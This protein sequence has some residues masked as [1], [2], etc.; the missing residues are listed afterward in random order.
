MFNATRQFAPR[1]SST[2]R[3]FST[4]ASRSDNAYV[5]IIGRIG[6]EPQV[7]TT[8]KGSEYVKYVVA[9]SYGTKNNRKTSWYHVKSFDQGPS[10]DF[11]LT[12][13]KG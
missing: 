13:Q 8:T 10:K 1:F 7:G 12:L 3:S 5:Q 6:V 9:S 11:L 4:T 2:L